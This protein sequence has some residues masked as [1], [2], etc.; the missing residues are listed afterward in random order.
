MQVSIQHFRDVGLAVSSV[1]NRALQC[2]H[3]TDTGRR[4]A[5]DTSFLGSALDK[6]EWSASRAG[7]H[8]IGERTPSFY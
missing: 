5:A 4:T 1:V 3:M 2:S 6:G 8:T 7:R